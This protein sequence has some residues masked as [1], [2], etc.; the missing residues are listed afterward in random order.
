MSG[1]GGY[2][3]Q[4]RLTEAAGLLGGNGGCAG[5]TVTLIRSVAM[6]SA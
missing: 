6:W 3:A 4:P 1:P 2:R 5:C